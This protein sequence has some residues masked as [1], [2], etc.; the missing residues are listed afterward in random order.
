MSTDDKK[1]P[2][3]STADDQ[4]AKVFA[5]RRGFNAIHLIDLGIE[6]GLFRAL[7]EK[8]GSTALELAER[9]ALHAPYVKTWCITAYGF[10][11]LEAD[12]PDRFRLATYYDQILA[13]PSHPRYLGGYV[14]LATEFAAADF[15]RCRD[16]F[17]TGA[18]APF[19]GRSHAFASVIG[20]AIGGLHVV[21]ARKLLP[22]L[23]H[24]KSKLETGAHVLEI[25]CG[26]ARF[27]LQLV[28]AWPLCRATGVDIDPTGI[29][30]ARDAVQN[31]GCSDRIR[32]VQGDAASV[33]GSRSCDAVVMIE[34]LHEIAPRLRQSVIN[35]CFDA[36][37]PGGWMLIVDETYPSTLEETRKPEFQFPLQT[38]FEELVWGNVIPTRE[39]QE[40]LLR[41]AGFDGEIRRALIGEGFAVLSTRR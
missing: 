12:T 29:A 34:V 19:Q 11:L 8:P 36:L 10:G 35:G 3:V 20:E 28:T 15:E 30:I 22:E 18:T 32:I 14:R 5:W 31:A 23:D 25:G 4:V 41:A 21:T 24:L 26:T 7:A 2:E 40:Q 13:A 16:A 17:R 37:K 39:E 1:K 38:G 6:L 33:V 27:L 9:L